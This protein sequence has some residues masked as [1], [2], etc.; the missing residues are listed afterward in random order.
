MGTIHQRHENN[1]NYSYQDVLNIVHTYNPDVICVEI[2]EFYF[3]KQSYLK[4][5]MLAS[6]YGF[7]NNKKVYPIDW[8]QLSGNP[9]TEIEEYMKTDSYIINEAEEKKR[10]ESSQIIKDFEKKYINYIDENKSYSFFNGREYNDYIRE[11]YNIMVSVYGD[12]PIN[13]YSEKRNARMVEL[14]DE[15]IRENN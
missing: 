13:L 6:V 9:K 8:F 3:R 5:M 10:K 11:S 1:L 7:D 4:E 12:S 2:P 14:I 15:V